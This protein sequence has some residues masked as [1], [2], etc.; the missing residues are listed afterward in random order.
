MPNE[1]TMN[2]HSKAR[3]GNRQQNSQNRGGQIP[4]PPAFNATVIARKRL[5]FSGTAASGN[6]PV[7]FQ[8]IYDLLVVATGATSATQLFSGARVRNVSIWG[9]MSATLA[10][11]TCAIEYPPIG[12]FPGQPSRIKSD[13]SM[14][15]TR[16]AYVSFRPPVDSVAARWLP[17]PN[18]GTVFLNLIYPA[19][20]IID[21]DLDLTL[22]NGET[23]QTVGAAVVGATAGKVYCR[24]LDSN[25]GV[26]LVPVSYPTI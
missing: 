6:T 1:C 3:R 10:P 9:P 7:T 22:Q 5:R 4:A 24:A 26:N 13:T 15:S 16:A 23:P 2:Q 8:D 20:S 12:A 19:G 21:I 11:V 18:I 17:A 14:G 25:G